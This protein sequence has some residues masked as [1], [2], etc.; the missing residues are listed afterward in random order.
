MWQ[1]SS[2]CDHDVDDVTI[3]QARW[4]VTTTADHDNVPVSLFGILGLELVSLF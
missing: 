4:P 3:H 2:G 1:V